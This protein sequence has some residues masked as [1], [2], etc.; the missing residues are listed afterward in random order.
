MKGQSQ[1]VKELRKQLARAEVCA[2]SSGKS[3][4]SD[5]CRTRELHVMGLIL[6]M[7]VT[8]TIYCMQG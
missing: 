6:G 8:S 7:D 2:I 5:E 4:S 3:R 1:I